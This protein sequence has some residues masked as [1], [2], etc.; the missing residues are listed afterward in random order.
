MSGAAAMDSDNGRLENE[1]TG[2]LNGLELP[3][4][5]SISNRAARVGL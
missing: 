3:D 1:N 5:V 4:A 2:E